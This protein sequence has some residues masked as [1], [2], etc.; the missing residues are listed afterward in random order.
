MMN[1]YWSLLLL[2]LAIPFTVLAADPV[3][4]R[5]NGGPIPGGRSGPVCHW[6]TSRSAGYLVPGNLKPKKPTYDCGKKCGFKHYSGD[7]KCWKSDL[8][9]NTCF[10]MCCQIG[11][12]VPAFLD[13][14]LVKLT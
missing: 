14:E 9:V 4:P 11:G 3:L 5:D 2:L 12:K 6:C 1:H 7:H 13:W 10:N 8:L